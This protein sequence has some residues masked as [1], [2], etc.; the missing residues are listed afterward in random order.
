MV[1][2]PPGGFT[3]FDIDADAPGGRIDLVRGG[4]PAEF[5][6]RAYN[7]LSGRYDRFG[8]SV[9]LQGRPAGGGGGLVLERFD[10]ESGAWRN[11][12][13][14]AVTRAGTALAGWEFAVGE[15]DIVRGVRCRLGAGS[16]AAA[17]SNVLVVGLPSLGGGSG[18]DGGIMPK[19][20]EDFLALTVV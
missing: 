17:G 20:N 12:P 3:M 1:V 19:A 4:P 13:A 2:Q 7:V 16:G 18:N 5:T 14:V 15:S 9:T 11:V 8:V 10:A 6:V